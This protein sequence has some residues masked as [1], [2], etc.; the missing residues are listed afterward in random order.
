MKR[1][2]D[3]LVVPFEDELNNAIEVRFA[4]FRIFNEKM[5]LEFKNSKI[6]T[7]K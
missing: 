7:L 1:G 3:E 2:A 4:G 5:E 6:W